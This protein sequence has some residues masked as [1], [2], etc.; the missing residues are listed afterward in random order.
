MQAY[1]FLV[2][3]SGSA[4]LS[5]ALEAAKFGSVC[6]VTKKNSAESNTNYAQGGIAS[7]LDAADSFEKHVHDTLVAGAGMC[8]PEV[9]AEV[10]RRGPETIRKLIALG[11]EFTQKE[12]G[13][14]LVREGGHSHHRIIHADDMTGREIERVLLENADSHPGI[15][16]LEHHFA[17][18]LI[19][20]HHMG[21]KVTRYTENNQCYGAYVLNL[22]TSKVE[23][24]LSKT[25]LLATGGAGQVYQH[26][27]NP[28]IATGDGVAMA[29]RAKARV[30]NMEFIQFHP[31]S[32]YHPD[33]NSFL[34]SEAVRGH[35]AK[36][37]NKAGEAFMAQYDKRE[38][39][40]P[41][42]IVARAIDDQLKKR[43]DDFVYLDIRSAGKEDLQKN[44]PNIYKECLR[45]GMDMSQD[46][47][48]IVPAAHYMCGGV[49]TDIHGQTTIKGLFAAGEVAC[50]G[51][52]GANRLA[53]NSLLEALV[54]ADNA[55][56]KAKEFAKN[57]EINAAVPEW[58]DSGT[59]NTEE[60]VLISHNHREL[61]QIMWDYVGIV[62][63]NLRLERAFRRTRLL[64]EEVES[65]YQ[66][67][68]VSEPLCQLRNM[69]SVAYL[70]IRSAMNRK[71]SRGLHYTTDYPHLNDKVE[72]HT[73]L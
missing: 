28:P 36:L 63:S 40:A 72:H 17:M 47:I 52:H 21:Q 14:H 6:I 45:H 31:T 4:G 8:D 48:P 41:R 50:T 22:Q 38:E 62:R 54:V 65:F 30:S 18:E 60:W 33:A 15:T 49:W 64:H 66:R 39:L 46:L 59:V 23:R 57:Q 37:R 34:I 68:K 55:V 20:E 19:T 69:I 10:V 26:T 13:L 67:T 29:Y 25:T 51:L 9:V 35:G 61:Q 7:V 42:D 53:S 2:L 58:D 56:L 32:L 71:E 11:A 27:T 44:F 24:I 5:F 12:G 1:D 43:G 70:I 3:G 16:I 73:I